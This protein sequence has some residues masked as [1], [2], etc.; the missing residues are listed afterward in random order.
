M[1]R[2]FLALL[3][4]FGCRLLHADP[5]V[6][7]G[8]S[9]SLA[10]GADGRVRSWG[11]DSL[12]ALGLGRPLATVTPT[13][14]A[15]LTGVLAVA[16]GNS[17]TVALKED[18]TVWAW[19]RNVEG[20]LGDG[21][22]ISR[23][24]PAQVKGLTDVKQV[25]AGG[26]H[27]LARR[28]DGTVWSWGSNFFG[29]LGD[30]VPAR[31]LPAPVP[32]L[33]SVAEVA[34]G[35]YHSLARTEAGVVLAW[36]RN[37]SGQLGDGT[38]SESYGGRAR[39]MPIAGLDN[40]EQLSGGGFISVARKSDGSLWAWGENSHGEVG[41]GTTIT[42]S[43]PALITSLN[44]VAGVS[45]GFSY[46]VARKNDGSV[47]AWGWS[48]YY[49]FPDGMD[50]VR[51]TPVQ[52]PGIANLSQIA[53]GI[54][55]SLALGSDGGL[56]GWG[57]NDAGALGDG[58]TESRPTPTRVFGVSGITMVAVGAA[59]SVGLRGDRTV[60]TWGDNSWG[61]LGNGAITFRTTPTLV[62]GLAEIGAVAA[63]ETSSFA[64]TRDGRVYEWG[65]RL[66]YGVGKS[67][68][69][70][71]A[72]LAN[73]REITAGR[74]HI[75]ARLGDGT[76]QGWGSNYLGA[77]GLGDD[78]GQTDPVPI[79]GIANVRQVSAGLGHTLAVRSDGTVWAWGDNSAG[80]LGDGTTTNRSRPVQVKGLA[81]AVVEVA[82]GLFHSMA[83]LA[84][85]SVFAWGGN[86]LNQ[87]GGGTDVDVLT[88]RL[89]AGL[90][91]ATAIAA[92]REFS[93]ALV[94]GKLWAWGF[95]FSGSIGC[96]QCDG[97]KGPVQV[98][99]LDRIKALDTYFEHVL[100]LREDGGMYAFGLGTLGELGDGTLVTRDSPVVVV[101]EGG[102]GSIAGN[103]W[104]LDLDPA[105]PTQIAAEKVPAFLVVASTQANNVVA[106]VR[107]RAQDLGK[108]ASTFV[109]AL[110]PST[111]VRGAAS[112]DERIA[113]KARPAGAK[114]DASIQCQ[115][116]QLNAQ[117]ELVAVSAQSLQAYVTGVLAAQGQSVNILN[118]VN[119]ATVAGA[120]FYVGY[121]PDG[122][123][124]LVNGTTRSVVSVSGSVSCRPQAPQTGWWY[125]PAEGGRGFSIESHGTSLFMAAF[126]YEATGRATWNF[127]GGAT[128]LDGSL[129]TGA[130]LG[131]TNGQTLTG[132][133]KQPTA[134]AAG[135]ITLS[136][137][138]ATHG[139]MF[140][141][142]GNTPIERQPFVQN[143]LTAPT[144]EGLPEA[145]WWWN[146][147]ESGR[148]FF[149]EWQDRRADLAGYMYDAAGNPTWYITVVDT[150]DPRRLSGNWW[151]FANGQSVG[152]SYRPAT[153]VNDKVGTVAIDFTSATTAT[154]TLPDGRRI[155]IVRQPF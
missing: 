99:G 87:V 121:G 118:A 21:T 127:A 108:T 114:A 70:E 122:N 131:T 58:T 130:F 57:A 24:T 125:N 64:L 30:E 133:Y 116:A 53:A 32:G 15:G 101:R 80:Q 100:L 132:A 8:A 145:G 2:L 1:A 113:P 83:R 139:T 61:Q 31:T 155:P 7:A 153:L 104:F 11:D 136:F 105:V 39:P 36:G 27:V 151:A 115:L 4:A 140:W 93:F 149:I 154:M 138:D 42:R 46:T 40:V 43:R 102:A 25:S 66:G 77:L 120:T 20:E 94:G 59:F 37:D 10:V 141:P 92:G 13:P 82:A 78:I 12:G 74:Y 76:L 84:D 65:N 41:D 112:A 142:G 68:P 23:S 67:T 143:G 69:F 148:G 124:M 50:G 18:G 47:W 5:S 35:G 109:F 152:G 38:T 3:L 45:A 51:P 95:N 98:P 29:E 146:S 72:G 63:G 86:S 44:G 123:A 110:A 91:A 73:V 55:H 107:Y 56:W 111:L 88:P 28:G 14:V 52:L 54:Y 103:D 9:H 89:V 60:L 16:A 135:D 150:P 106:D 26:T 126:H 19:G 96:P 129:F 117:G 49:R 147:D 34:A 75:V 17:F 48:P 85:G 6:A 90:P 81:N 144:Q 33:T 119:P 22:T 97:R 134:A 128:S 137:S 62:P 71:V 79:P